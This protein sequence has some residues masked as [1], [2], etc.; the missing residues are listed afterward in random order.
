[1]P[2]T[3]QHFVRTPKAQ[4]EFPFTHFDLTGASTTCPILQNTILKH[5]AGQPLAP[6]PM[7]GCST[8]GGG[9]WLAEPRAGDSLRGAAAASHVVGALG[10]VS[11]VG[12]VAATTVAE[13]VPYLVSATHLAQFAC[14]PDE[15][16]TAY[17][18]LIRPDGQVVTRY[19]LAAHPDVQYWRSKF[20]EQYAV[21]NPEPGN[22]TLRVTTGG[23][24]GTVWTGASEAS[25]FGLE[26]TASELSLAPSEAMMLVA[27]FSGERSEVSVADVT[28]D[29]TSS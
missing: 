4:H 10:P 22:W 26:A 27:R 5:M 19:T 20:G 16:V 2:T 6:D 21:S 18:A 14:M 17:C 28:A 1:M 3:T 9:P 8:G 15:G 24:G 12:Y 13:D 7:T 11:G 29:V 23:D 25:A